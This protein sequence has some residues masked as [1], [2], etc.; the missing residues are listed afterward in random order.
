MGGFSMPGYGGSF[1]GGN[2][3][4]IPLTNQMG[5]FGQQV[6][7]T[8]QAI[9]GQ[10][11]GNL[12]DSA[13]Y[14]QAI[15]NGDYTA[16]NQAIAPT[17]AGLSTAYTGAINN[18]NQG[19]PLGGYR[20]STMATMPQAQASQLGNFIMGLQPT[21][22]QQLSQVGQA[23][24][25]LGQSE[26]SQGSNILSTVLQSLLGQRGQ[27]IQNASNEAQGFA[28]IM[29][30]LFP[31]DIRVKEGIIPLGD[32]K[33]LPFYAFRYKGHDEVRLGVMAQEV[34][35]RFPMAVHVGGEDERIDPWLV[36]Y[37]KLFTMLG[38]N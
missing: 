7:N 24:G 5:P 9:T 34:Y 6:S 30:S 22:A 27:N 21:A 15:L 14:W 25:Q 37:N 18:I 12:A 4:T 13:Q 28:S 31:S 26:T 10:G 17:A 29:S 8:G 33:G 2:L 32:I 11:A 20:A 3:S 36:D 38:V 19:S 16:T 23:Q 1:P 35:E